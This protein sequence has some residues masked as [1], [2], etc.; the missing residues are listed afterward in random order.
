MD[1]VPGI[2]DVIRD[3]FPHLFMDK[4]QDNSEAQSSI[5][6]RI[7]MKLNSAFIRQRIGDENQA[8]FGSMVAKEA[9]KDK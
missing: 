9:A 4:A 6:H 7:F 3:R 2:V 5:L 8:I 1:K